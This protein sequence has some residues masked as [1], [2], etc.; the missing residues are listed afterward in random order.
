MERA[1]RIRFGYRGM[2]AE[3]DELGA[4]RIE[5]WEARAEERE[6]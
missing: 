4:R 2:S 3:D 5:N 1:E 6:G